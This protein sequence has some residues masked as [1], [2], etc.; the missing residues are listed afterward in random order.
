MRTIAQ[1]SANDGS[2]RELVESAS[3][4]PRS[5]HGNRGLTGCTKSEGGKSGG[6]RGEREINSKPL[7]SANSYLSLSDLEKFQLG[8]S[9][10]DILKDVQWRGD[11]MMGCLYKGKAAC[12]IEYLV[13]PDLKIDDGEVVFAIFLDNKFVKFVPW[14]SGIE[15]GDTELVP[16]RKS[17]RSR[18]KPIQVGD[19]SWLIRQVKREPANLADL[20]TKVKSITATAPSPHVDWGLTAVYLFL[21]AT[22][23]APVPPGPRELEKA[24]KKN[25]ELRDQFNASRLRMGMTASEVASMFKAK[26]LE[27]GKVGAGFYE[28]YGSDKVDKASSYHTARTNVLVLFREGKLTWIVT[29][30]FEAYWRENLSERFLDLPAPPRP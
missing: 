4:A 6:E 9:Q 23:A 20:K 10:H 21:R 12:A 3:F 29:Q 13:V 2:I 16:Y 17:M 30:P 18:P 27:S 22:G 5:D 28:I 7:S 15:S 14:Q 25:A 19:F 8:R 11:T 1:G 26:P 24:Y